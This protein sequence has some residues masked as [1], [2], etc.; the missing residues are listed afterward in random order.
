MKK[1]K[2]ILLLVLGLILA[3]CAKSNIEVFRFVNH[4]IEITVGEET[5][6][7][8]IYGEYDEDSVVLYEFEDKE[9]VIS[10]D[11]NVVTGLK[12]GEVTIRATIDQVKYDEV[13]VRV[14]QEQISS[15]KINAESNYFPEEGSIQLS[16]S[17]LPDYLPTDV[18][19][20]IENPG[21]IAEIDDEGLLTINDASNPAKII[22]V[23]KSK[24]DKT[25]T[26]K[27]AFYVKYPP[28]EKVEI[29]IEDNKTQVKSG[30]TIQYIIEVSPL[31]NIENIKVESS[32]PD[33]LS[34]EAE[35]QLIAQAVQKTEI[36]V[37]TCTTWDGE[38]ASVRVS[39]VK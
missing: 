5:I 6:L 3:G 15:M 24:Y 39:I 31:S 19:W 37:I 36:V 34:V 17:V 2:L 38:K 11:G 16:V 28:T 14:V 23:A 32:K 27:K 1:I 25:I 10:L 12:V 13:I 26:C 33:I 9:G 30:E 22:V 7:E 21:N 4:E 35:N 20:S 8:L 29:K 18:D